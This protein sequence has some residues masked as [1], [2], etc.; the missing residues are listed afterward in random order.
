MGTDPQCRSYTQYYTHQI[1]I[2][3]IFQLR[4]LILQIAIDERKCISHTVLFITL[5][6]LY[7]VE[8]ISRLT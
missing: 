2:Q 4:F 8:V 7:S 1:F 5:C 6:T 3:S